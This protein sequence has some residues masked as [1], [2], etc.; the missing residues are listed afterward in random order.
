M[1]SPPG[2]ADGPVNLKYIYPNGEQSFSPQAFSYSA[3]PQYAI[4]SGATP[5]GG[6]PGRISGYGMPADA[7][8]GTLTVGNNTATITTT[9]GQYPPYTPEAFPSTYLDFTIPAE[10]L[11]T[12][13]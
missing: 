2:N 6:V 11:G 5:N 8:G 10:T 13:T 3:Y 4:I 7:S 9:V 12:P 1:V